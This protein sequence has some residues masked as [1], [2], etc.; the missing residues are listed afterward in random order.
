MKIHSFQSPLDHEIILKET[1]LKL[2]DTL[3]FCDP[4]AERLME[5]RLMEPL[6][7]L[8]IRSMC[9]VHAAPQRLMTVPDPLKPSF[10]LSLKRSQH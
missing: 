8:L 10:A 2:V 4:D 3:T 1:F 6:A 7:F 9:P 5:A